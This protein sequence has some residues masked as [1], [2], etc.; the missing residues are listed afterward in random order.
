V[1]IVPLAETGAGPTL[2]P[3]RRLQVLGVLERARS[4]LRPD[5]LLALAAW[6]EGDDAAGIASRLGIDDDKAAQRTLRSALKRLR[7]RFA[8]SSGETPAEHS[9]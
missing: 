9:S 2:D 7:D 4:E 8:E 3:V 6:L 5:Q 1:Q